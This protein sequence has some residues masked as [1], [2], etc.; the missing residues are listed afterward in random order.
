[1]LEDKLLEMVE[2]FR[3]SECLAV[4]KRENGTWAVI[5]GKSNVIN[6]DLLREFEPAPVQRS[7]DFLQRTRFSLERAFEIA[8]AFRK[9]VESQNPIRSLDAVMAQYQ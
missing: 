6:A 5:H 3:V 7:G 9:K 8:D 2:R 1:M 4:E